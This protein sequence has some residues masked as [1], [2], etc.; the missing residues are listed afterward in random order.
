[1]YNKLS[2]WTINHEPLLGHRRSTTPRSSREAFYVYCRGRCPWHAWKTA[3]KQRLPLSEEHEVLS[4]IGPPSATGDWFGWLRTATYSAL[5]ALMLNSVGHWR[6]ILLSLPWVQPRNL[7]HISVCS[8]LPRKCTNPNGLMPPTSPAQ[9]NHAR[10]FKKLYRYLD[11]LEFLIF[12]AGLKGPI[13]YLSIYLQG[14]KSPYI[15]IYFFLF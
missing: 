12:L 1:M 13:S 9:K 5:F 6:L 8:F 3:P 15:Y 2:K 4:S 11:L 10:S 7:D 14:L